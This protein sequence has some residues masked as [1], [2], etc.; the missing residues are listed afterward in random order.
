MK[1]R[2]LAFS[3]GFLALM[4]SVAGAIAANPDPTGK[5][6][7][8][9]DISRAGATA[10]EH[11][12]FVQSLPAG[13]QTNVRKQCSVI[14]SQPGNHAPPVVTFCNDVNA[15]PATMAAASPA[16]DFSVTI[17]DDAVLSYNLIGL[18]VYNKSHEDVGEIKDLVLQNGKLIGY[19]V[20]VGGFLGIGN[21]YVVVAPGVVTITYD[22]ANSKWAALMDVSKD[23]LK[24][25]PEFKYEGRFKH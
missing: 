11:Q 25:A 10:E 18:G 9:V 16:G 19:I 5:T 23:Q 4:M 21:R 15:V 2:S 12:K 6:E 13:D 17:P 1:M 24:N 8:G 7:L 14:V 20:S 22:Q 3:T